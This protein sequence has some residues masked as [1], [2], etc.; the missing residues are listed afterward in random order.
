MPPVQE[1]IYNFDALSIDAAAD[2]LPT[3]ENHQD[4]YVRSTLDNSVAQ[5]HWVFPTEPCNPQREQLMLSRGF[6]DVTYIQH[7]DFTIQCSPEQPLVTLGFYQPGER[8]QAGDFLGL[9]LHNPNDGQRYM[10]F[11]HSDGPVPNVSYVAIRKIE[12]HRRFHPMDPQRNDSFMGR[13][14]YTLV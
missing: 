1:M 8:W 10:L 4:I 5:I 3:H 14:T 9:Y 2:F 12:D 6:Q 13:M 7:S 11:L